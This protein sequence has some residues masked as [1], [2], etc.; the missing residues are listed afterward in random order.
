MAHPS[1]A[2]RSVI[3]TGGSRGL[4]RAMALGLLHAGARVAIVARGESAPL[5]ET[6]RQVDAV[7]AGSR[8]VTALGD[9]RDARSSERIAADVLAVF[10]RIDVLVNN[11][12]VPHSGP[13]APFWRIDIDDWQRMSHTNTDGVFFMTRAVVPS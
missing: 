13:G 8:V 2:G 4:G 6:L 11:A 12:A 7:G 10:G 1:L 3:V 5:A 9:L